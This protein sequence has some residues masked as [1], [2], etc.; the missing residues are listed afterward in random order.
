MTSP[1][2]DDAIRNLTSQN[3][4]VTL[5]L[6]DFRDIPSIQAKIEKYE[7]SLAAY[8]LGVLAGHPFLDTAK[9]CLA[10][11][12]KT[13]EEKSL[14]ENA[15]DMMRKAKSLLRYCDMSIPNQMD[16]ASQQLAEATAIATTL[17][18]DPA[19]ASVPAVASFLPDFTVQLKEMDVRVNGAALMEEADSSLRTA[20]SH[21]RWVGSYLESNNAERAAKYL[22]D[23][24]EAAQPL[25][26]PKFAGLSNVT[27]FLQELSLKETEYE[28]KIAKAA[29]QAEF[30]SEIWSAR[31]LQRTLGELR[32]CGV[33]GLAIA[34]NMDIGYHGEAQARKAI[35]DM[36]AKIA[37]FQ[38]RFASLETAIVEIGKFSASVEKVQKLL[39][40]KVEEVPPPTASMQAFEAALA[41]PTHSDTVSVQETPAIHVVNTSSTAPATTLSTTP[42]PKPEAIPAVDTSTKE[43][44]GM[45]VQ[46][47][48]A[49]V[50]ASRNDLR[51][52]ERFLEDN[53]TRALEYLKKAKAPITALL[54]N[55]AGDAW[56]S[57]AT[58]VSFIAEFPA[59]AA[60]I[61]AAA[62][63]KEFAMTFTE[64][65]RKVEMFERNL[66]NC[67]DEYELGR[68]G[69]DKCLEYVD[70]WNKFEE[71]LRGKYG[72][73]RRVVVDAL[74]RGNNAVETAMKKLEV[75]ANKCMEK[76]IK[77]IKSS[78]LPPERAKVTKLSSDITQYASSISGSI[79]T[80][81]SNNHCTQSISTGTP[82]A[83][84][85]VVCSH[86]GCQNFVLC[87]SCY[88]NPKCHRDGR[89]KSHPVEIAYRVEYGEVECDC[90]KSGYVSIVILRIPYS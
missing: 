88:A 18:S 15:D 84:P 60:A 45:T 58:L 82:T 30:D 68:Y 49:A 29:L 90:G 19:F 63:E 2:Q 57:D 27:T 39:G 38:A 85:Y 54:A 23:A 22:S 48:D 31:S 52:A 70:R 77:L 53:P 66:R 78:L 74:Q 14:A 43:P 28:P 17:Q 6:D 20:R 55:T 16:R 24:V 37:D 32:K 33:R 71:E 61:E 9:E 72:D 83:Q 62:G 13:F 79:P 5:S 40:E 34:Y 86:R 69:V 26:D 87:G 67:S 75:F 3:R 76:E 1:D 46:E 47:A 8:E 21:L 65:E 80:A 81:L 35:D 42:A 11:A 7:Q 10:N 25:R 59:K 41:E 51:W 12:K 89:W 64:E 56:K 4:F 50:Y 44:T 36:K 73:G